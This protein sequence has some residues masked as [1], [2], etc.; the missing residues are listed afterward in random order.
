MALF[1]A[2]PMVILAS[3]TWVCCQADGS[4]EATEMGKGEGW[5]DP[6]C[7]DVVN[8]FTNQKLQTI[9]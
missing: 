9:F 8:K 2:S 3:P 4:R 7:L 1:C 6:G 5:E